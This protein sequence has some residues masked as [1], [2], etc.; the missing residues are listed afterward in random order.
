VT[1]GSGFFLVAGLNLLKERK[2]EEELAVA[3]HSFIKRVW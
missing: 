1:H 3:G 2:K